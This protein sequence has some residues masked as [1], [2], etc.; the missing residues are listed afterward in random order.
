MEKNKKILPA[1]YVVCIYVRLSLEDN[2]VDEDQGKAE[3]GSITTQR[4][5][6]RDYLKS[7]P[8]FSA[9]KI[10]ER[11]DDGFSGTQFDTRPACTEMIEMAKRGDINCIIVKDFSRFGRNYVELGNYLEQ[12]FPFL[13]IRF[14]SVND[15]YDSDELEEGDT[16]GLSVA[17]QN[18]IYDYYSKE[19]SKKAKLACRQRAE[20]GLYSSYVPLYGYKKPDGEKHRIVISETEGSIVREIFDMKF[21]GMK[22]ADIARNLN[23]RQIPC[24]IEQL[25][26]DYKV[27]GTFG[28]EDGYVWTASSIFHIL[29][30]EQYTGTLVALKSETVSPGGK[31]VMRP[32]DEWFRRENTHEAIVSKE[33]FLK[34]QRMI[35]GG[36][37]KNTGKRNVFQCGYCGRKLT[38]QKKRGSMRCYRGRLSGNM[39]CCKVEVENKE[40]RAALLMSIQDKARAYL[41]KE[42][43]RKAAEEDVDLCEKIA[44]VESAISSEKKA[45][46][47]MYDKYSDGKIGRDDFLRYKQE[48][49]ET[50]EGLNARLSEMK[51]LQDAITIED[52]MD[53]SECDAVLNATE[54]TQDILD[55]FVECVEVFDSE[56]MEIHWRFEM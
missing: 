6:I 39:D 43:R 1:S 29:T 11:C 40:A 17:F 4:Q 2:D 26:K 52:T 38:D 12:L 55:A 37:H 32:K 10:I 51:E 22:L 5:M 30:N 56:R 45:W 34:V 14:I 44:S 13:G 49:D 50:I 21:G 33:E 53:L 24:P 18:L 31:R 8:E 47:K 23:N 20:H 16:P 46:M 36:P 28:F 25:M 48:Y 19:L 9:C 35:N 27:S 54:L 15:G 42:E 7:R 3:S 41:D